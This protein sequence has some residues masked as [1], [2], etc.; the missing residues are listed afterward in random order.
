MQSVPQGCL[1]RLI[2]SCSSSHYSL[3]ISQASPFLLLFIL[4]N[5]LLFCFS[6]KFTSGGHF[7]SRFLKPLGNQ[8]IYPALFCADVQYALAAQKASCILG[9]VK[10]RVASRSKEVILPSPLFLWDAAWNTV[11]TSGVSSTRTA[12]TCWWG[13]RE[14]PQKWSEGWTTLP[15]KKGWEIWGCSA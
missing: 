5:F 3:Y 10:R 6:L 7:E 2:C 9:I 1:T 11:H 12:L 4:Y 15:M 13:S 14:G 8:C